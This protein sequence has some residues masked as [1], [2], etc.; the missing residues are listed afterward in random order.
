[1]FMCDMCNR[2][3]KYKRNLSRH[4]SEKHLELKHWNCVVQGCSAK[5]IRREYLVDHLTNIHNYK[6]SDARNAALHA[7]RGNNKTNDDYY[8]NV[9]SDDEVLDIIAETGEAID[10]N[11]NDYLKTVQDFDLDMFNCDT[12]GNTCI[13]EEK[14]ADDKENPGCY[15]DI[16]DNDTDE[17]ERKVVEDLEIEGIGL[18]SNE[19]FEHNENSDAGGESVN[20]GSAV[21]E[22]SDVESDN[23][24][25]SSGAQSMLDGNGESSRNSEYS[26]DVIVSDSEVIYLDDSDSDEISVPVG[27]MYEDI[28]D[29]LSDESMVLDRASFRTEVEVWTRTG[30]R[31]TTYNG[32]MPVSRYVKYVDDYY[33]YEMD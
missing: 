24:E 23:D 25:I 9:S 5:L 19:N 10:A 1:M 17:N 11:N 26:A 18:D 6:R 14:S 2:T 33:R 15:S 16:S 30:Y 27:N 21:N 12:N 8:E 22:T 31:Y 29:D 28:S 32:D 20:G 4:I 3:Y 13:S 7:S